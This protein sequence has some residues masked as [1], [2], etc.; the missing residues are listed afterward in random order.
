MSNIPL[1]YIEN[2]DKRYCNIIE[3]IT[4]NINDFNQHLIKYIQNNYTISSSNSP[5]N[6]QDRDNLNKNTDTSLVPFCDFDYFSKT[7]IDVNEHLEMALS[8]LLPNYGDDFI[9]NISG[10]LHDLSGCY[11][12]TDPSGNTSE[13]D[14]SG[15]LHDLSGNTLETDLSGELHDLS[16]NTLETDLSGELHD[17]SG[18]TLEK[19]LSGEL[20]DLSGNTLETDLS[21]NTSENNSSNNRAYSIEQY[22]IPSLIFPTNKKIIRKYY[23]KLIVKLHP[24]KIKSKNVKKFQRYY[25]E[26]KE[27]KKLNS[28]YKF[29]LL[30]R[31]INIKIKHT[32]KINKAFLTE[33]NILKRYIETLENSIISQWINTNSICVKDTLI[34][35]YIQENVH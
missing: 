34:Q 33:I 10:G 17:L 13:T 9:E 21:G 30:S 5:K 29:Y 8:G 31:K 22:K 7:H 16:G 26:C 20:H 14:L 11:P 12:K 35:K 18:N 2:L 32:T 6:T 25:Q 24:D 3:N 28:L 15:E 1:Q 23:K 27:A 19:D 4:E